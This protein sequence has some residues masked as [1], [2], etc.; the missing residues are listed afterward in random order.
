MCRRVQLDSSIVSLGPITK[1]DGIIF[2]LL[3]NYKRLI[4]LK[5]TQGFILLSF[6]LLSALVRRRYTL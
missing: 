3:N 4:R 2:T 5:S 1:S 6:L